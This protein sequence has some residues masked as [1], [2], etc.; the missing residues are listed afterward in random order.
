VPAHPELWS[1]ADDY[2]GHYRRYSLAGLTRSSRGP[3]SG[4]ST[5]LFHGAAAPLMWLASVSAPGALRR[6]MAT[7]SLRELALGD[8][9]VVP[10]LNGILAGRWRWKRLARGRDSRLIPLFWRP[11][12]CYPPAGSE[13][14]GP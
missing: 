4:R 2:A 9:A 1:Y 3:V 5:L 6:P 12:G 7:R 13:C 14:Y 10:V 8:L 11:T